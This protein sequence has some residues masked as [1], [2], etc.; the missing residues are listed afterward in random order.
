MCK[1]LANA[2]YFAIINVILS[3]MNIAG[4]STEDSFGTPLIPDMT[5]LTDLLLN[6]HYTKKAGALWSSTALPNMKQIFS[7]QSWLC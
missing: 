1:D 2:L 6:D 3:V 7:S 4:S 5:C